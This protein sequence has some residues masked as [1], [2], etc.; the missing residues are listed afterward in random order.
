MRTLFGLVLLVCVV[1][2][3]GTT[4]F[5]QERSKYAGQETREVKGLSTDDIDELRNGRGWGLAK[6]AEL[7]GYPGPSHVLEM[8]EKL[9][10]SPGQEQKVRALFD[11]MK[12]AAVPLGLELIEQ[13]KKL[14]SLFT[15]GTADEANLLAVLQKIG[16]VRSRL[17]FVH[18]SAHLEMPDILT[19]EQVKRYNELR[20]YGSGDP[21]KNIPEG[22][23]PAMWK[24]H[25]GCQE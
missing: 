7:N 1:G 5:S 22:H 16:E 17:R 9:G 2:L 3:S 11:K 25:N 21:C 13:E 8:K 20:G 14:D 19:R 18:L 23:D 10:L 15:G 24:K 6:S 4:A 12:T